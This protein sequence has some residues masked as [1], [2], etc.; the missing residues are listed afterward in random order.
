MI[1]NAGKSSLALD[2]TRVARDTFVA[3]TVIA[4]FAKDLT[5]ITGGSCQG[6]KVLILKCKKDIQDA[7]A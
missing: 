6:E 3:D 4:L 1:T 7:S 2:L 5:G